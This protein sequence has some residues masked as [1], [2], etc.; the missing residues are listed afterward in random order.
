MISC[1]CFTLLLHLSPPRFSL[2]AF[3]TPGGFNPSGAARQRDSKLATWPA[4][5]AADLHALQVPCEGVCSNRRPSPF[6]RKS[7]ILSCGSL[8]ASADPWP[9]QKEG[10]RRPTSWPQHFARPHECPTAHH[11]APERSESTDSQCTHPHFTFPLQTRAR[12]RQTRGKGAFICARQKPRVLPLRREFRIQ[13]SLTKS[14]LFPMASVWP[15]R[16]SPATSQELASL[17]TPDLATKMSLFAASHT[18]SIA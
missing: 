8:A 15:P 12:Y 7:G 17:S 14:P 6:I 2:T 16:P 10:R 9:W 13:S 11:A 5:P 18:L 1:N 4:W 3:G